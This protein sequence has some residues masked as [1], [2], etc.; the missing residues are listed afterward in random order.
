MPTFLGLLSRHQKHHLQE[1]CEYKMRQRSR[2][3]Q[4]VCLKTHMACSTAVE[5]RSRSTQTGA[6]CSTPVTPLATT[7]P[8]RETP[9]RHVR[10]GEQPDECRGLLKEIDFILSD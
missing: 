3:T 10:R 9:L 2:S 8:M 1:L 7:P 4:T 6:A 5:M